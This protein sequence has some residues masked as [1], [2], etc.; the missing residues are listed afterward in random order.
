MGPGFC[1]PWC[2]DL[3]IVSATAES[4]CSLRKPAPRWGACLQVIHDDVRDLQASLCRVFD[5][6][7][8]R[9]ASLEDN[10][11]FMREMMQQLHRSAAPMPFNCLGPRDIQIL[12]ESPNGSVPA[13]HKAF[14][15]TSHTQ[16]CFQNAVCGLTECSLVL[17]RKCQL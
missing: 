10:L 7:F 16:G 2:R 8:S 5:C 11:A 14:G 3:S 4:N 15:T 1:G 17:K 13:S 9:A 12:T 6:S